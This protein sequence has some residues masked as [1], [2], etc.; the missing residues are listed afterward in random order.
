LPIVKP[1]TVPETFGL[2]GQI[3]RAREPVAGLNKALRCYE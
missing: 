1:E 2:L 3:D